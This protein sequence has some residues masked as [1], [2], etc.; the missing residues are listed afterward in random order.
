ML[1]EAQDKLL[2]AQWYY[3]YDVAEDLYKQLPLNKKCFSIH[4]THPDSENVKHVSMRS[5]FS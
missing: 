2:Q 4:R 3:V 5:S 1:R